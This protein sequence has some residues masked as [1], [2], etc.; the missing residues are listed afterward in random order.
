MI[1]KYTHHFACWAAARAIHNR[2]NS[3]TKTQIIKSAIEYADLFQFVNNPKLLKDYQNIHDNLVKKLNKKLSWNLDEKY[4]V[5]SKI[6]A[7]YLKVTVIIPQS[8]SKEILNNIYPPLDSKN[9]H[10]IKGFEKSNWTTLSKGQYKVAIKTLETQLKKNN[11][12]FIE[13]EA[14]N[15]FIIK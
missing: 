2:H 4:G 14:E 1:L 8:A 15:D 7:I 6:I 10:K 9:L 5:I 13:F 11:S 3:G 12:T